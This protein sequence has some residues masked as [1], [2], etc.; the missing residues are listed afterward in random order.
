ML[1]SVVLKAHF[2]L[3]DIGIEFHD[4]IGSIAELRMAILLI[5]VIPW[6]DLLDLQDHI[7]LT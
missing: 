1:L 5:D 4:A 6:I 3:S 2:E 7:A